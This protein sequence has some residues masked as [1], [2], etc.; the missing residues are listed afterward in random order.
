MG[1]SHL[2]VE[3]LGVRHF[4]ISG[5]TEV[6]IEKTILHGQGNATTTWG[7][8]EGIMTANRLGLIINFTSKM[9]QLSRRENSLTIHHGSTLM[10]MEDEGTMVTRNVSTGSGQLEVPHGMIIDTI[11]V[12]IY[13][14]LRLYA[15][16]ISKD[17]PVGTTIHQ[18]TPKGGLHFHIGN[19][20]A[21]VFWGS[22]G[23]RLVGSKHISL[24][25]SAKVAGKHTVTKVTCCPAIM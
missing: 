12:N 7:S 25:N 13:I 4:V 19:G 5:G 18:G 10:E 9:F 24:S 15:Y 21:K 16:I 23:H 3:N 6:S 22:R 2:D 17:A 8:K 11:K 20:V 14:I 1:G